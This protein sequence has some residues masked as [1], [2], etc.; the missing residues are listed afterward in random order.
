[1]NRLEDGFVANAVA[2]PG[3]PAV[4][5]RTEAGTVTWS[6]G[7]LHDRAA[8]IAAALT[9]ASSGR[10]DRVGIVAERTPDTFAAVLGVLIAG[11]AYVP[12]NPQHPGDRI[13]RTLELA[14]LDVILV[15]PAGQAALTALPPSGRTVVAGLDELD[16]RARLLTSAPS[17][18]AAA[19]DR[20]AYLL[21]TSGST[22]DPK[23]VPIS[24]RNATAFMAENQRH[25]RLT[26]DDRVSQTF[27]LTFD[28]S[29]FDLF[30]TWGAGACLYPLDG[31]DRLDPVD[32]VRSHEL[33]VWFSVPSM[34]ALQLNRRALAPNSMPTLRQ[35]LFCGEALTVDVAQAW[36]DAAPRSSV[37]N[38]YGPTELT[39]ACTRYRWTDGGSRPSSDPL[40]SGPTA[41]VVPIG[42]P[43]PTMEAALVDTESTAQPVVVA[44]G[45][46]GELCVRGPQRFAGYWRNPV[47][48]AARTIVIDGEPYYRTGDRAVVR[49]GVLHFLGRADDQV[50]V[51]GHRV[52]LGDVEAA[53]R[54]IDGVVDAVAFALPLDA[55]AKTDL[56]VAITTV[57]GA[58]LTPRAVRRAAAEHLPSYLRPR[59][60][61]V[62]DAFPLNVNDKIDRRAVATAIE[63]RMDLSAAAAVS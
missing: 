54:R 29:V 60:V 48:T 16:T 28:L 27:D 59:V 6:Y 20:L 46:A 52:E 14:D 22:G 17:G 21:F 18:G 30:M 24:H 13:R 19:D 45:T 2:A 56:G 63:Q 7:E 41:G 49:A 32:V 38:L 23:G 57:E 10:L 12:V 35:S 47:Q 58:D 40:V 8:Q 36:A 62:F 44:P 31:L 61:E 55:P 1:M 39:I 33:T 37:E 3:A 51:L 9:T 25:H 53:V 43:F 15:D 34:A 5:A 50:Q 26:P 42:V 4:V 11:A